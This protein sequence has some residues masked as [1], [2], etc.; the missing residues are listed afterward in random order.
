MKRSR[1][2]RLVFILCV[3]PVIGLFLGTSALVISGLD[4]HLG[5]ADIALVL[6]NKVELDGT[7]SPRL[8]ARLDRTL[9]LYREG[10]FPTVIVSG[11]LGK[12]GFDE[13]LVM[14]NY[15]VAH[16]IPKER[17]IVDSLGT[18]TFMSAKNTRAFAKQ[19]KLS[20]VLVVSQYYHLPRAR[21]ALERFGIPAV[22]S[23]H[24]RF[25]E[26]RDVYSSV[27]EFFGYLSYFIRSY[28]PE[29]EKDA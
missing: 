1:L 10:Y 29:G 8:R 18:T 13:A 23:A 27:R 11:G 7:P 14:K 9:E 26:I 3:V 24:A 15:L 20:R 16:G 25:F 6:G 2:K 5:K 12:E 28:N 17:V 19:L 4:D 21:L 22:Y